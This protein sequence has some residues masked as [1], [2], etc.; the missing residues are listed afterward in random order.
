MT[1]Y[2]LTIPYIKTTKY[3]YYLKRMQAIQHQIFTN[4]RMSQN[5]FSISSQNVIE[6]G[7]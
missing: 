6:K 1:H 7:Y 3:T 5:Y 4:I 2:P